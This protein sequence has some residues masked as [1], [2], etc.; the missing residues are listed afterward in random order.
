MS[1]EVIPLSSRR[2]HPG[3]D[4]CWCQPGFVCKPHRVEAVGNRLSAYL[5]SIRGELLIDGDEAQAVLSSA[6]VELRAVV[7]ET[8]KAQVRSR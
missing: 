1:A 3:T 5:G 7:E 8:F 2:R 4:S 6:L